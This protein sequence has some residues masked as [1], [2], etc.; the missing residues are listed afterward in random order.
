LFKIGLKMV[1]TLNE[2]LSTFVVSASLRN[3][4]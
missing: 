3:I 1:G 4:L 2:A